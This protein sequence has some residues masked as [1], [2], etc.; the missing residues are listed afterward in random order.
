MRQDS[1]DETDLKIN[2][3]VD[4]HFLQHLIGFITYID[5]LKEDGRIPS[6]VDFMY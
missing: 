4:K 3:R 1:K 6:D 2:M 5:R